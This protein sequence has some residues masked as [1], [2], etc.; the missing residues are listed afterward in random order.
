L[1]LELFLRVLTN[2]VSSAV[3]LTIMIDSG[4][5][6]LLQMGIPDRNK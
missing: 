4:E 3:I 1:E 2:S 5:E 6:R